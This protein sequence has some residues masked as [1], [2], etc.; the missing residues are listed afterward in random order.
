MKWVSTLHR[1]IKTG[2]KKELNDLLRVLGQTKNMQIKPLELLI[3]HISF[4]IRQGK[5][6]GNKD[7]MILKFPT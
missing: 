5:E 1:K 2:L 3:V 4:C 6:K 7:E